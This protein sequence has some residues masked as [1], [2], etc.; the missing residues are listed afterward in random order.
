MALVNHYKEQKIVRLTLRF[1]IEQYPNENEIW[2]MGIDEF[3]KKNEVHI[4]GNSLEVN[5]Y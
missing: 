5:A 2:F 3:V 1:M 4:E